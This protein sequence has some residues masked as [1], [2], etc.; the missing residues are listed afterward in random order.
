MKSSAYTGWLVGGA[1]ALGLTILISDVRAGI[2]VDDHFTSTSL[3]TSIWIPRIPQNPPTDDLLSGV[4]GTNLNLINTD[5]GGFWGNGVGIWSNTGDAGAQTTPLFNRPVN[6]TEE[7]N[8]YFFGVDPQGSLLRAAFGLSSFNAAGE[9]TGVPQT[10]FNFPD[11][12]GHNEFLSYSFW[13]RPDD[14]QISVNWVRTKTVN[15]N[16]AATNGNDEQIWTRTDP[17]RDFRIRVL[18]ND[19]EW[20]TRLTADPAQDPNNPWLL[21]ANEPLANPQDGAEPGGRDTFRVFVHASAAATDGAAMWHNA[22][23]LVNRILVTRGPVPEPASLALLV[24][25]GLVAMRRRRMTRP[26]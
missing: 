3:D 22:D 6:A 19:I 10:E 5:A 15:N 26:A 24:V 7:V 8:V 12:D 20:Y 17:P 1:L 16:A 4:G 2:L 11:G 21:I 13:T 9:G 23:L 14:S 18:A 25:G